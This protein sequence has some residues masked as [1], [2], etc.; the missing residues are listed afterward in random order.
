MATYTAYLRYR[1]LE[2]NLT[3][4]N[5]WVME[6]SQPHHLA[7]SDAQSK[8][9]KHF[10]PRSYAPGNITVKGRVPDQEVYDNLAKYIRSHHELLMDPRVSGASNL[11][12]GTQLPLFSFG[13]PSEGIAVQG[14]IV[15]F[16][17]G[18]KRW[19]VAPEFTFDFTVIKDL[20]STNSDITP[21]FAKRRIWSGQWI[22]KGDTIS[23][24]SDPSDPSNSQ[25]IEDF[26][27]HL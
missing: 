20:H 17:A 14:F 1:N 27:H 19:N 3:H 6:Y 13:V 4:F 22:E 26:H 21:G 5:L 16:E 11:N 8:L 2:G 9:Y 12:S 25:Q 7:G 18:A 10:Y 24:V 15:N 23:T